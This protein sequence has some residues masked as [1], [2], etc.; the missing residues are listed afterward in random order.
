MISIYGFGMGG[1]LIGIGLLTSYLAPR[2][3]P[4]PIFGVRVGYSFA[5]RE[6]WDKTNRF[7]GALIALIGIA[8]GGLSA[9]FALLNVPA[10]TSMAWITGA[11]IVALL[12]ATGWMFVYARRLAQRSAIAREVT[13]VTFRWAFVAPVLATFA[14]LVAVMV[15]A[16]PQLPA[17][18]LAT[19]F[20]LRNQPDGWS[21]RVGFILG[22]GGLAALYTLIDIGAVVLALRE[23]LVAFGR[24]GSHWRLEPDRGLL[25]SGI[26]FSLVNLIL[27][28][29]FADIF[30]F[31]TRGLHLF[32]L[33]ALLWIGVALVALLVAL[34]FLLGR[35]S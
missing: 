24:W 29:V 2:V 13:P 28:A 8:I 25:Y 35:R 31:N 15:L 26:A 27:I 5:N 18:H 11:M 23:P 9:F 1:L 6:V 10:A 32:P 3:G 19:H 17:E 14:L 21:S 4:N 20:D 12:A 16:Y 30:W 22:F 7:G 34:F 33:S